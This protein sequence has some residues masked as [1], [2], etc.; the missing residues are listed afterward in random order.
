M[1]TDSSHGARLACS[2]SPRLTHY[3]TP[4]LCVASTVCH[5]AQR[6]VYP[7]SAQTQVTTTIAE[8]RKFYLMAAEQEIMDRTRNFRRQVCRRTPTWAGTRH[9]LTHEQMRARTTCVR[10]QLCTIFTLFSPTIDAC[11][12]GRLCD[13]TTQSWM[14]RVDKQHFTNELSHAKRESRPVS[15]PCPILYISA[16]RTTALP[17]WTIHGTSLDC[18]L[19]ACA[20]PALV[21]LTFGRRLSLWCLRAVMRELSTSAGRADSLRKEMPTKRQLRA[22]SASSMPALRM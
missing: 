6:K 1:H 21:E 13:I 11:E 16:D 22:R 5:H 9:S 4:P 17:C 8:R 12:Q 19:H 20:I 18:T 7:N 2:R 15:H 14:Q 3:C 10:S